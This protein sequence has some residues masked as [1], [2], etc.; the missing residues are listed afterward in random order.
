LRFNQVTVGAQR[1]GAGFV[2][3]LSE[4]S[5]HDYFY[6]LKA[7]GVAQDVEHFK[8]AN[9]RHHDVGN[10]EV[11]LLFFGDTEC[12]FA[13]FGRDNVVPFRL[14]ARLINFSQVIVVFDQ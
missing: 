7:F 3:G 13:V 8:A 6:V 14:Q 4:S 9:A 12:L 5:Q 10:N 11:W 2:F 1:I